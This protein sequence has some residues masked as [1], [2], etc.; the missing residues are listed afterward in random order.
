MDVQ[1]MLAEKEAQLEASKDKVEDKVGQLA[2]AREL[3][4]KVRQQHTQLESG[5]RRLTRE[6]SFFSF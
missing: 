6:L 2:N 4:G 1:Q 3:F 5:L